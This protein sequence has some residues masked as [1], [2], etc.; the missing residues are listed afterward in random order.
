VLAC[1]TFALV[2]VGGLV[3]TY[4][5]GT[6]IPDWPTTYGHW[7]YPLRRWLW[8]W[9]DLAL[10]HGHRTLA[11]LVGLIAI[12][13][14]GTLWAKD[15]RKWMRWLAVGVVSGV[16]LQATLGGLRVLFHDQLLAKI[17]GCTAP[18]Y[19]ALCAAIVTLTSPAWRH[20]E[21]PQAHPAARRLHRFTAVITGA[22]YLLIVLG[23]QLRYPLPSYDP[24][25]FAAW[26]WIRFLSAGLITSWFDLWV[27]LKL[28]VAGLIL[29]ALVWLV[30]DVRRQMR[31]QRRIVRRA[32]LLG[33]LFL[34]QLVLAAATWVANYNWPAW[35][36]DNF[37]ASAYTVVEEGPLQVVV[38]T[39]HAAAGSLNLA[40]GLCLMLWTRRLLQG[41]PR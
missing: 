24:G 9:G 35:L 37:W 26:G 27:C 4:Q 20:H 41:P 5:A 15:G 28:V 40:A 6:A 33:G 12:T 7:F 30:I 3:T 16:I 38:T 2:L 17:H 23:A 14:A 18:L 29:I 31:R 19:F 1:A 39:A 10:E 25:S 21:L 22:I 8:K 34:V 32:D 36:R 11:Q 13:L